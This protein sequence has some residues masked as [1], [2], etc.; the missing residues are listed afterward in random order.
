M[1][2]RPVEG[3]D[4]RRFYALLHLD[5]IRSPIDA[6]RA[7][8]VAGMRSKERY[9]GAGHRPQPNGSRYRRRDGVSHLSSGV[10]C[11]LLLVLIS[12]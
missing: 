11:P 6:V 8:I 4:K 3:S 7:A 12:D 10:A 1:P 5:G 9:W 2:G